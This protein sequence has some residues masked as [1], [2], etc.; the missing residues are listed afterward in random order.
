MHPKWKTFITLRL[1]YF[2]DN[3]P[4]CQSRIRGFPPR[5]AYHKFLIVTK[6]ASASKYY[7]LRLIHRL[8]YV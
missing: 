8:R 7:Y 2:I 1:L 5:L 6:D 3:T 4:H